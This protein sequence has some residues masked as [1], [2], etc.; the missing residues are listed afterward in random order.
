[1]TNKERM[2]KLDMFMASKYRLNPSVT[3][4]SK[5]FRC[6]ACYP[7][8]AYDTGYTCKFCNGTSWIRKEKK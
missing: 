6:R 2:D 3:G 4:N 5:L 1:M 7:Q 8:D